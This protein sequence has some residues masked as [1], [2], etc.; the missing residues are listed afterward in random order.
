MAHACSIAGSLALSPGNTAG[1][2]K[3]VRA[4]YTKAKPGS[5][6]I[7]LSVIVIL[8]TWNRPSVHVSLVQQE[9]REWVMSAHAHSRTFASVRARLLVRK[10]AFLR[11]VAEA[12]ADTLVGGVMRAFSDERNLLCLVR[13]CKDL[14]EELGVETNLTIRILGEQEEGMCRYERGEGISVQVW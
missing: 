11:R 6:N 8:L 9:V 13:E 7:E 14:E 4:V 1:M 2:H 10:L 5:V 12:E 3:D